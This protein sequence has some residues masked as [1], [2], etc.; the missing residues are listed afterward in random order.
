M[1]SQAFSSN[2]QVFHACP[3][4]CHQGNLFTPQASS[5][6]V[7]RSRYS[8]SMVHAWLPVPMTGQ[9]P[10]DQD[11][12]AKNVG[13]GYF[14]LSCSLGYCPW[15]PPSLKSI[16]RD[17]HCHFNEGTAGVSQNVRTCSK[18]ESECQVEELAIY[19][20]TIDDTIWYIDLP[21][22]RTLIY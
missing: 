5:V 14:L 21:H 10:V 19:S 11:L 22:W 15:N 8:K 20:K 6:E 18:N 3:W 12:K 7:K 13:T 4:G 2:F 16:L 9:A 17:L 1:K